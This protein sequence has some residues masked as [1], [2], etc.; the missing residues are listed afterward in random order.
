MKIE[1]GCTVRVDRV[2]IKSSAEISSALD[3]L[4]DF[5][6]VR[7]HVLR[8]IGASQFKQ[9]YVR[10]RE[11]INTGSKTKLF[12]SYYPRYRRLAAIRIAVVPDDCAG[13]KRLELE[14]IMQAFA[15]CQLVIVEIAFDFSRG[16]L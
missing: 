3:R 12:I 6:T 8:N 15:P 13:L 11:M 1:Y 9:P 14:R 10:V 4:S 2:V 7:D 5:T 16:S